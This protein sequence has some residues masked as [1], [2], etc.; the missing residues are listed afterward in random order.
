M[1]AIRLFENCFI[2][3]GAYR[4]LLVDMQR[5]QTYFIP[6]SLAALFNK[7]HVFDVSM[8][9]NGDENSEIVRGYMDF[10]L[11]N[12][13]CFRCDKK[14]I[15]NFPIIKIK[16][17]DYPAIITNVIVEVFTERFNEYY[18]TL[19]ELTE[20]FLT[21]YI[22]VCLIGSV[23]LE[24]LKSILQNL[25]KLDLFS[26]NIIFECNNEQFEDVINVLKQNY[27]LFRSIIHSTDKNQLIDS[28]KGGWGNIFLTL[29][30]FS[31]NSCGQVTQ[32]YFCNSTEHISESQH[33]NTCLNRKLT[34]DAKGDIRNCPNTKE[35]YGNIKDTTLEEAIS[36][37][38]FQKYWTINKDQIAVCKDCEFRHICKDCRAFIEDPGDIYSKP[39]KCGY[40]PYK[41]EWEEWSI[42]PLK[43]K[44]IDLYGMR[45]FVT[46]K[47]GE[48]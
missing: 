24:T 3:K 42:N 46:G 23:D 17:W 18:S 48:C 25:N 27:K 21:R 26:Y 10:L 8:I 5:N 34:I 45:D 6:N 35:S 39:L 47:D 36:K 9:D 14:L 16:E 31:Y 29:D 19:V 30:N 41:C 12:E 43:Q 13:L 22:E 2:T 37:P 33:Y 28:N 32:N 38:E 11:D 20:N 40:N 7:Q 1:K 4:S 15:E 44:A